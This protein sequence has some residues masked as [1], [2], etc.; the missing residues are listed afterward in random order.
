MLFILNE[1]FRILFM[2]MIICIRERDEE[3]SILVFIGII[4]HFKPKLANRQKREEMCPTV[5]LGNSNQTASSMVR[6]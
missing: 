1:L 3:W 4:T 5:S 6:S 2:E